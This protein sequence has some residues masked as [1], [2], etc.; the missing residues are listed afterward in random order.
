MPF[1]T[2]TRFFKKQG[3]GYI[4]PDD[5]YGDYIVVL[6]EVTSGRFIEF[7]EGVRVKF[8]EANAD[9]GLRA[10]NVVVLAPSEEDRI[11]P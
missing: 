11:L 7:G 3:Y 1:G 5:N 6:D 10:S 2:I 4:T 9:M 8:E